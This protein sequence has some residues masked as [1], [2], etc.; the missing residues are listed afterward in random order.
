MKRK[1]KRTPEARALER[2]RHLDLTRRLQAAIEHYRTRAE[3]K[4]RLG[5]TVDRTEL[6][7]PVR[8]PWAVMSREERAA[9]RARSKDL[10]RRLLAVIERYR[11]I[12][13]EKRQREAGDLP[14]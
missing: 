8:K 10:D 11:A 12:N 6:P 1:R 3:A 4:R 14:G 9:E 7:V 2:A 5:E 13:A